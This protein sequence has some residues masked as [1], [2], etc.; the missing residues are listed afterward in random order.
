MATILPQNFFKNLKISW[1][2]IEKCKNFNVL[3]V[4]VLCKNAN[5]FLDVFWTSIRHFSNIMFSYKV[6]RTC[7]SLYMYN[8]MVRKNNVDFV[9]KYSYLV[10]LW[11]KNSSQ[12]VCPYSVILFF[13]HFWANWAKKL[14]GSQVRR[15]MSINW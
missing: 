12:F 10:K 15:L 9:Q 4:R 7:N 5:P 1:N 14:M 13:G 2:N 6:Q 3:S 8:L 11:P